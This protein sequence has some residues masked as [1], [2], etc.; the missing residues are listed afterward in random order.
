MPEDAARLVALC[1]AR[2]R[3]ERGEVA[4]RHLQVWIILQR[5]QWEVP[6]LQ[7]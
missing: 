1:L 5:Q 3:L 7:Q 2:N 4:V 6:C